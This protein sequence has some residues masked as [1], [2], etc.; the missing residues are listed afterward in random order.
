MCSVYL[1]IINGSYDAFGCFPVPGSSCIH[2]YSDFSYELRS[3]NLQNCEK[4]EKNHD[5]VHSRWLF[6]IFRCV[7]V[8]YSKKTIHFTWIDSLIILGNNCWPIWQQKFS[9]ND[10]KACKMLKMHWKHRV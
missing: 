7:K 5:F 10:K 3:K 4:Y 2:L 6:K 8:L 9:G 1:K